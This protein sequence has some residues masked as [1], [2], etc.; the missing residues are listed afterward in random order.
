LFPYASEVLSSVLGE[1]DFSYGLGLLD[2][3]HEELKRVVAFVY[4]FFFSPWLAL[5]QAVCTLKQIMHDCKKKKREKKEKKNDQGIGSS[6]NHLRTFQYS[7]YCNT[8]TLY[9]LYK[10][11]LH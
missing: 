8:I 6:R 10:T 5:H 3:S 4:R 9:S 2:F 1:G 11:L 7:R